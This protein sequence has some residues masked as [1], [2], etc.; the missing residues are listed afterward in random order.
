MYKAIR[1]HDID[2]LIEKLNAPEIMEVIQILNVKQTSITGNYIQYTAIVK[3]Y[4]KEKK[5]VPILHTENGCREMT[6]EE[7][8]SYKPIKEKN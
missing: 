2:I 3:E 4:E 1:T 5:G 7:I 8:E 6:P